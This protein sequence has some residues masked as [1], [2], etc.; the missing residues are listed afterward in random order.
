MLPSTVSSAQV[1]DN[2]LPDQF[3]YLSDQLPHL[4][5]DIRYAGNNNFTGTRV[6]GYEEEIAIISCAAAEAFSRAVASLEKQ[7]YSVKVFDTYRPTRAVA[8]FARWAKD[9]DDT[10][11]KQMYYP[12]INKKDLFKLG[13]IAERSGH[14]RGSTIDLTLVDRSTGEEIDMGSPFD[15]FDTLSNHGSKEINEAQE[16]NRSILRNAMFAAGFTTI[17]EE[18]WHFT[19]IAEPF[20]DSYFNFPVRRYPE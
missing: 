7:G 11:Q 16:Y 10:L 15:L 3:C 1:S 8:H 18:W 6:D 14:S 9:T 4:I 19:L 20:P 2:K 17:P 5:Y 13:Y 12:R